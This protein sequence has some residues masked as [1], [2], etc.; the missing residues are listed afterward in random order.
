MAEYYELMVLFGVSAAVGWIV[1]GYIQSLIKSLFG[2]GKVK[3]A[4]NW[5]IVVSCVGLMIRNW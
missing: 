2:D 4:V 3:L 1:W 5:A